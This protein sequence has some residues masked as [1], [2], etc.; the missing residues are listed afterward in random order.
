MCTFRWKD[1]YENNKIKHNPNQQA[2][3]QTQKGKKNNTENTDKL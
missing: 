1:D 2:N 3:K